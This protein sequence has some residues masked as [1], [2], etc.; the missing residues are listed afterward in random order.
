[1]A[2]FQ[3]SMVDRC[4][5]SLIYQP[6]DSMLL[7]DQY[8]S[9]IRHPPSSL[10]QHGMQMGPEPASTLIL[11]N[12]LYNRKGFTRAKL[13]HLQVYMLYHFL[14]SLFPLTPLTLFIPAHE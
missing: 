3:G 9:F 14:V 10:M 7:L 13:W 5:A 8:S 11:S 12:V 4:T 2:L 1:M 6:S